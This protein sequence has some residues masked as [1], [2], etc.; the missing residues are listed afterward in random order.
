MARRIDSYQ[1]TAIRPLPGTLWVWEPEKAPTL[2]K[3]VQ[4]LWNGEEWWV[5]TRGL[6]D[7]GLYSRDDWNDLSR[8]W[9][10]CHAVDLAAGPPTGR[11]K[12]RHD[13]PRLDTDGKAMEV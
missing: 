6:P 10:A 4:V 8:F 9:E 13:K 5:A 2:I 3:V 7:A 11:G 12:T 1:Q